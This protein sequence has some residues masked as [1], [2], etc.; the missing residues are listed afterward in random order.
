MGCG[1]WPAA[2]TYPGWSTGTELTILAVLTLSAILFKIRSPFFH[3]PDTPPTSCS[4][5]ISVYLCPFKKPT[6]QQSILTR[7]AQTAITKKLR[8]FFGFYSQ[9]KWIVAY[10]RANIKAAWRA[11]GIQSYSPDAILQP[12]L[13]ELEQSRGSI[14]RSDGRHMQRPTSTPSKFLAW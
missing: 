4:L 2:P 5:S 1:G 11:A 12:L 8:L 9:A 10:T 7:E 3:I 13:Q 6:A 14:K